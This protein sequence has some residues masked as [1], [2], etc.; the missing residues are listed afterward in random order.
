MHSGKLMS[1]CWPLQVPLPGQPANIETQIE[2][3]ILNYISNENSIILAVTPATMDIANSDALKLARR[4]D[5]R[6]E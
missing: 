1:F 2:D 6:G 4:V 3:L 5:P